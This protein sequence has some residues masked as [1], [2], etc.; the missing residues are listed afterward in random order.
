MK[1]FTASLQRKLATGAK[2]LVAIVFSY[3]AVRDWEAGEAPKS[4]RG[5]QGVAWLNEVEQH[6]KFGAPVASAAACVLRPPR[7]ACRCTVRS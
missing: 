5:H 4:G 1:R 3:E 6:L 2:S 7:N